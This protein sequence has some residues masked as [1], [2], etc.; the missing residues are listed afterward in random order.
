MRTAF[1]EVWTFAEQRQIS[2]RKASYMLAVQRVAQAI[3]QRGL[4][5]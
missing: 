1:E 5:P 3:Q 4:F 2:M